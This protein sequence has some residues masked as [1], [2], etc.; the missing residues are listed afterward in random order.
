MHLK[1]ASIKN[2]RSIKDC[3][4]DFQTDLQILVG[5]N[6]SGKSNV[7]KALSLIDSESKISPD[8]IREPSPNENPITESYVRFVFGA[9][10]GENLIARGLIE[11]KLLAKNKMAPICEIDGKLIS[12]AQFVEMHNEALYRV[13]INSASRAYTYWGLSGKAIKI[14]GNWKKIVNAE[15]N[16]ITIGGKSTDVSAVKIINIDDYSDVSSQFLEDLTP[17]FLNDLVGVVFSSLLRN[18][19]PPCVSWRYE[20]RFLLPGKIN[21]DE[22]RQSP[23][24]CVPLEIMFSLA[25]FNDIPVAINAAEGRSNGIRNLLVRVSRS[26]TSHLRKVWP[27][28]K[29]LEVE[30]LQNGQFLEAGI[31][32]QFNTYSLE[33]RSDG[34]KRFFTFLLMLSAK[35]HTDRISN[36]L[37]LIDEPEI[38]L[39][40]SGQKY[41]LE[42]L[43]EIAKK[44]RVVISTHSIFMIDKERIDRHILVKKTKELTTLE[45]AEKSEI[46]DEEVLFRALGFSVYEL[47]K[48]TNI[49]FEGWTD[50]HFFEVYLKGL[51]NNSENFQTLRGVGLLHSSGVKNIHHIANMCENHSRKCIIFT[52]S[53]QTSMQAKQRFEGSSPWKTYQDISG[54]NSVTVEDYIKN[55]IINNAIGNV[56]QHHGI[57]SQF[58]IDDSVTDD[59]LTKIDAHLKSISI[60]DSEFRKAILKDIKQKLSVELKAAHIIPAYDAVASYLAECVTVSETT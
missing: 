57:T 1:Y 40:P 6:E 10:G 12:I 46:T 4:I 32:D 19:I 34:F 39:H 18:S 24:T 31:K 27:E 54:H 11:K 52:D 45:S 13:D 20:E 3:R 16:Q 48:S 29:N 15:N 37:I 17:K 53:D 14:L 36:N 42:A 50:K 35:N 56:F 38:G 47:L 7:L 23:E 59:K 60:S 49:V 22:F 8:D 43:L 51:P 5:I 30:I 55:Q 2:Y 26:T 25:G 33:R 58:V 41:V 28:W 21:F 9:N 44:N